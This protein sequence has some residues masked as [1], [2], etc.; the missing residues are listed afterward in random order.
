MRNGIYYGEDYDSRFELKA[1][2]GV[3]VLDFETN[4]LVPHEIDPVRE[5]NVLTP[6]DHWDDESGRM[7]LDFGQNIAGYVHLKVEGNRGDKI[8]IEHS[9]VLGPERFFDNRNY[10]GARAAAAYILRGG[11]PESWSPMFTFM[12]FRYARL[13]FP[14]SVKLLEV[15]AIPISSLPEAAAGFVTERNWWTG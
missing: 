5:L 14:S 10:R 15:T 8:K 2:H 11:D 6:I 3:E 13:E 4:K 9:E 12:G 7:I 1:G